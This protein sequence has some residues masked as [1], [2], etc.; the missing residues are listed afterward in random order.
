MSEPILESRSFDYVPESERH[1]NVRSQ[2]QLWFMVNAQI[3]TV[4]TGAVGIAEGLSLGW[5]LLAIILGSLAGTLFQAFHGAQGPVMGLP[6]MI[7]SRVQFG[8]KGVLLPILAATLS[9]FGFAVFL[10]QTSSFALSDVT[11]IDA[12]GTFQALMALAAALIAIVGFRLV[13]KVEAFA[14]WLTLANFALLTVA[15]LTV[16]P[17]GDLAAQG[18]WDTRAFFLQ[19]GVSAVYQLAIAPI[20]SDYTRYLPSKTSGAKVSAAV[21]LGTTLSAVWLEGIGATVT[22]AFPDLDTI[23]G[24]RQLGD[25]F[26]FGLGTFTM[27]VAALACLITAAITAYSGTLALI[28]GLEAFRPLKPTFRLRAVTIGIAMLLALACSLAMSEG[29]LGAF[30]AFLSIL[31][32]VLI[33]WTAVNLTDYYL[34]RKGNYSI[35]DI[36][37]PDGGLYGAWGGTG[38]LA[39]LIGFVAMVP[40]FSTALWSGPLA[41]H[42][43][44]VDVSFVIGLVVSSLA[45]LVLARRIDLAAELDILRRAP[46]NT[47]GHA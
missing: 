32:Y 17:L 5:A 16:L 14:S 12:P 3:L 27:L 2:V 8:S 47:L 41:L 38:I 35:T 21:F 33:P 4:Y 39:Y 9:P 34:V 40:F 11:G 43:G 6:Q 37:R 1:G 23:A 22:A 26:G 19:F 20:V 25:A 10:I 7:Q 45:Y 42:L 28:S 13:M 44:G 29:T 15:V 46:L 31:G 24:V 30:G 36:M 18:S